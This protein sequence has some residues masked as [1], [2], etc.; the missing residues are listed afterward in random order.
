MKRI[1][2]WIL[3]VVFLGWAVSHMLPRKPTSDLN[4]NGFGKLPVL[5][6]GRVIP[7]RSLAPAE[8]TPRK[9]LRINGNAENKDSVVGAA[10]NPSTLEVFLISAHPAHSQHF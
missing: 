1:V 7:P 10:H 8:P 4:V 3:C 2:P 5:A 9:H 6:G